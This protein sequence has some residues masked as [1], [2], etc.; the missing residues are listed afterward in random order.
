MTKAAPF[1]WYELLTMDITTASDFYAHVVGWTAK[2]A[3]GAP[4]GVDYR[5]L[6]TG[7]V[8]AAGV[9]ALNDEACSAG[10]RAG[11]LG[12]VLV[13][14]V[15]GYAERAQS[16]GGSVY[17]PPAD[18]PNVGRFAIIGD[19]HGAAI[20]LLKWSEPMDA[21]PAMPMKPGHTGWHELMAGDLEDDFA[22]YAKLFGWSK[23]D[24]LDMGPMGTYRLFG[25]NG[26]DGIGGM[27][28]KPAD[29]PAPGWG[30]YFAVGNIDEAVERVKAKGGQVL[31]GPMEVP[32][33]AWIING[34][35]PEGVA[36]SLVG[37]K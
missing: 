22:F 33:G 29:I 25:L 24:D 4:E 18:I 34:L 36:F 13:D 16:L 6:E 20:G 3:E 1:C 11:W 21:A 35:D 37:W 26:T 5:L 19:T 14:D 31:N 12:Y 17:M 27:M 23:V 2:S 30:Y 15:D 32:G 8:P 9:M 7:N 10:A 28:T